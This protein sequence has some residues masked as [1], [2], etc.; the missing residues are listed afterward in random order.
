MMPD[1]LTIP[2]RAGLFTTS[3]VPVPL[4]GVSVVADVVNLCSRVTITQRFVNRESQ[5]IEAVYLFP[6]DEGA[7][8]CG[9]EVFIDG[10]LVV[11]KA[12]EREAAFAQYDDAMQAG[13]GAYLLDGERPDVFQ[14]SVGNLPPGKEALLKVTYVSELD[15]QGGALRFVVPTTVSPRYAPASDRVG[16]GRPDAETLN[17]PRDW[18]VP[19]GLNLTVNLSISGSI[20]R[21]ESPSHPIS[22]AVKD[23]RTTVTLAAEE[24]ALDRDFVLTVAADGLDTP[25]AWVEK[26]GD[27]AIAVAV[28]FVPS[29]PADPRPA[30]V[31]FLVDESGSMQGSSIEQ[32]RNALQLCLR[33][34]VPGCRF[35]IVSFGSNFEALFPESRPYDETS[36][37]SASAFVANMSADRGGTEILPALESVLTQKHAAELSRQVVVLTDGQVSNTDAVLALAKAHAKNT[38]VFT[39]GIGAGASRHLV[40]GLARA[41]GGSAESIFPGERI[42]S[43]VVRLFGRLLAPAITDVALDW[44]TLDV[45]AAPSAVPPLFAGSRLVMY[46]FVKGLAQSTL[47]L[48][49]TGVGPTGKVTF[50]V[51]LDPS[52]MTPGQTIGT[53]AARARIRELEESAD[54]TS[55]RASRQGRTRTIGVSREIIDLA[56]RYNLVSR[57]TSLVA[58]E[59]RE[60]RVKGDMKLRRVPIA[61]TSGWGGLV[62]RV[63]RLT[64]GARLSTQDNAFPMC[65]DEVHSL[66]APAS[67][68]PSALSRAT[69]PDAGWPSV[70]SSRLE[71]LFGVFRRQAAVRDDEVRDKVLRLVALQRAD[72]A[73]ELTGEFAAAVGSTLRD[74]ER[75]L[76]AEGESG[77]GSREAWATSVALAWLERHGQS[78]EVEWRLIAAKGERWLDAFYHST[79][80]RS[81]RDGAARWATSV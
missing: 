11:G 62:D 80:G 50:D 64:L 75:V 8:V 61:L 34:M 69:M 6:L 14:A 16:V 18:R 48:T 17:P 25:R 7:A 36:L 58:V 29:L 38:R 40:Q 2:T 26:D 4:I 10:T 47:T 30:E 45:V 15:V 23:G 12:M 21:I 1:T 32:V 77:A 24:A 13:H 72:G 5:P 41:G 51:L 27:G 43:K 42:E 19:Y 70:P 3:D 52:Q 73:W 65:L 81:Y 57:E 79:S 66:E 28:S 46:G 68:E 53:L 9:F 54:W 39:F 44:G 78:M 63:A 33:S 55:A 59:R 60:T 22:M 35:N 56:V 67:F 74:L 31:I 20:G 37:A 76:S 49:L 71:S